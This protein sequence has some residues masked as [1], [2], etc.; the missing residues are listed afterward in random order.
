MY[1]EYNSMYD[2][3]QSVSPYGM[4]HLCWTIIDTQIAK[5][6]FNNY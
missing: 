5:L 1:W 2:R 3:L 6:Y 4:W